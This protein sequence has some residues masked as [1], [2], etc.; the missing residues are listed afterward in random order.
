MSNRN[1]NNDESK[2]FKFKKHE[3]V[4]TTDPTQGAQKS[5]IEYLYYSKVLSKPF[6]SLTTLK[7][8][9]AAFFAAQRAKEDK[10]AQ[11]K[12]DAKK[13]EDAFKNLNTIRRAYKNNI[14]ALTES[15]SNDLKNLKA[16]FEKAKQSEQDL[17]ATA[18]EHYAAALKAFTELYPEGY[19]LTLKDGDFE[20]TISGSAT[21]N[22]ATNTEF[23]K[24]YDIFDLFF[25]A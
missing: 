4:K 16:A 15:Y 25:R 23:P 18:E 1:Y 22:A 19:H 21:Q 14:I 20:T 8:A 6:E 9:E 10:A 2:D 7:D 3:G 17:L 12:A 13:V 5:D 24:L 11:K